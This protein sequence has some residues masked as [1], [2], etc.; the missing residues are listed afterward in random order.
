MA[1]VIVLY[2]T[3][4]EHAVLLSANVMLESF[5]ICG[6]PFI[7]YSFSHFFGRIRILVK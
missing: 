1:I 5:I 7:S 3:I 4:N 6:I 2:K